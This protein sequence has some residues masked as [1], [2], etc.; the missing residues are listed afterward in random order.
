MVDGWIMPKVGDRVEIVDN[1]RFVSAYTPRW[2][3]RYKGEVVRL[4][5]RTVT[6]RLDDYDGM[7]IRVDYD[8]VKV[9]GSA[10]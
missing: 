5:D 1:G 4:N 10:G 8:D 7:K 2:S 6:I 3:H 9:E